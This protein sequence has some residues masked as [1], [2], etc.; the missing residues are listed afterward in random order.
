[1]NRFLN[2]RLPLALALLAAL[3]CNPFVPVP[4]TATPFRATDT[5]SAEESPEDGGPTLEAAN[6]GGTGEA[7][8]LADPALYSQPTGLQTYRTTLDYR[9]EGVAADGTAVAGRVQMQGAYRVEPQE[10]SL[11][12]TSEGAALTGGPQTFVFAEIGGAQ[13]IVTQDAGCLT[14]AAGQPDNPFGV[15]LNTGGF[16]TGQ[17]QRLLPDETVN[18]VTT[19][20]Y[21]V[22]ASNLD[23]SDPASLSVRSIEQG[24][25]Y[26][27]QP[28]GYVVR[29]LL[30]G[31]GTSDVLTGN[32]NLEG[33]VHYQLDFLDFDQPVDIAIPPQCASAA[34]ADF[35]VL[36][37]AFEVTS[38]G[39]LYSY[40]SNH[41][42]DEAVAFYR[43][44]MVA[45]GWT[46][47]VESVA[48]PTGLMLFN[49]GAEQATVTIQQVE[50]GITVAIASS[51]P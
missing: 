29:V 14:S 5:P 38:G 8:N 37:D 48:A 1:M 31:R 41:T 49:R 19:A 42:F 10:S 27:A 6:Q 21:A 44:E 30:E 15:L 47:G 11:T 28:G 20:V 4:P 35:P 7:L 32:P 43:A 3:A 18:G 26:V 34:Q 40:K 39:G 25:L 36:N 33:D 51:Q 46:A 12:F 50:G 24:R 45:A 2:C 22:D 23:L 9:F 16:L 17:A 13:Y